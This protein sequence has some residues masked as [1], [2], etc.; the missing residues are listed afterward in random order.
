MRLKR[1]TQRQ[2]N[3]NLENFGQYYCIKRS[4]IKSKRR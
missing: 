1:Q 4:A 2:F 3:T